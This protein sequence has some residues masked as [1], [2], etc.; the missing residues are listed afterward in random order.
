MAW[1]RSLVNRARNLCDPSKVKDE[2][3]TIK[4]FASWNVF[5]KWIANSVVKK[6]MQPQ[7]RHQEP[8]DALQDQEQ[9]ESIYLSLPYLGSQGET[10][11]KRTTKKIRRLLKKE[12]P[13]QG[14]LGNHKDVV[15]HLQQGP[16]PLPEQLKGGL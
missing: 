7:H 2:I 3:R 10:L 15:L 1:I 9:G 12:R 5:P 8:G 4:K 13:N 14:L 11:V 6:A 16:D